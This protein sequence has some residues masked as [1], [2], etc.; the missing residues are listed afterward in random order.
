MEKVVVTG[1][2]G[3]I[4]SNFIHQIIQSSDHTR[5]T[6]LDYGKSG[7]AANLRALRRHPRYR[8]VKRDISNPRT[9]KK[10]SKNT[11]YI[12]NF[13]A[14]TH[15]DRSIANP[16]PFLRSNLVGF[17]NLLEAC[18]K[19]DLQ[20]LV[21]VS[22]DEVYGSID[23]GSFSERSPLNPSSPYSATKA[24]AD[25]LARAW[26]ETYKV[27][28][29]IVRCT[30]N[31]GPYQHPEKFIPKAIL[32]SLKKMKIPLYGGGRQIRDWTYVEDFCDGISRVLKKGASGEIYNF[33]SGNEFTNRQVAERIIRRLGVPETGVVDVDDRPGHDFRY[34]I[35]SAKTRQQLGW[36]PR[37]SF[38]EAL[39]RTVDWYINNSS[40][41]KPLASAKVL[42]STP[43]KES[44]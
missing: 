35:S 20:K 9:C 24:A 12:V 27:P 29:V 4:G 26:H 32:R 15:V 6:N 28:V 43:W 11:D 25:M 13:A 34:S 16:R 30:N 1:G 10:I 37:H 21:H 44:E 33:S 17:Y 36:Q 23:S 22:T 19:L 41:W 8:L 39:G 18:R 42:S 40:W 38:D 2:L 5:V 14:E 3:F 31:F 7:S